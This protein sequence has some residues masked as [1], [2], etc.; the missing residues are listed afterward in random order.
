MRSLLEQHQVHTYISGHHHV[1]YPG[2]LGDL[3]LL[4]AGA[5]GQGARQLIGSD[6]SPRQTLTVIDLNQK[7]SELTYHTYD[8]TTWN[9]ISI[10][11]LPASITANSDKIIRRDLAN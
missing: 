6:L 5:L 10:E 7:S 9:L 8:A 11:E 3:E 4:H 2:K 1:Y